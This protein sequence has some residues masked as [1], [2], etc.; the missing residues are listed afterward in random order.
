MTVYLTLIRS[1]ANLVPLTIESLDIASMSRSMYRHTNNWVTYAE[2][3]PI[4]SLV[5]PSLKDF[6]FRIVSQAKGLATVSH[7]C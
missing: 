1:T 7:I 2:I 6:Q 5:I 3:L 4:G